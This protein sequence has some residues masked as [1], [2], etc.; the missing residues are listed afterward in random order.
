MLGDV[1][2]SGKNYQPAIHT[3]TN[4]L[5]LHTNGLTFPT[6]DISR[7][8]EIL[9]KI[10]LVFLRLNNKEGMYFLEELLIR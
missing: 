2:F 9:K 7:M 5:V 6:A 8:V 3:Y 10:C 1:L 4:A